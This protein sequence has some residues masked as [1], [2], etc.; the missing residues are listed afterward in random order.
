MSK[1]AIYLSFAGA[2]VIALVMFIN[3][4]RDIGGDAERMKQEKENAQMLVRARKGAVDYDTC[5]RAGG[6]YNF[7]TSACKLSSDGGG[8]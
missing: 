8:R 3:Y 1:I 5:D 6:L 4:Q 2:A 7:R